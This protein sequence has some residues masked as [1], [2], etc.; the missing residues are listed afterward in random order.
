MFVYARV[1]I[2]VCVYVCTLMYIISGCP[3]LV[4][5]VCGLW[6]LFVVFARFLMW[7]GIE[8]RVNLHTILWL[9]V[10]WCVVFLHHGGDGVQSGQFWSYYCVSLFS[11]WHSF[12]YG[13][14]LRTSNNTHRPRCV[15]KWYLYR[16]L[17]HSTLR[18]QICTMIPSTMHYRMITSCSCLG[19]TLIRFFSLPYQVLTWLTPQSFV[20]WNIQMSN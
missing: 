20:T 3:L 11:Y 2:G 1:H 19:T 16:R 9:E 5:W 13:S 4:Y 12:G 14:R 17:C 15:I 10:V 8:F 6:I 7:S 18:L